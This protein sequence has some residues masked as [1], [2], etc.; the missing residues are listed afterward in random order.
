MNSSIIP[1]MSDNRG[2]TVTGSKARE[3]PDEEKADL[4]SRL[5]DMKISQTQKPVQHPDKPKK[6]LQS[7]PWAGPHKQSVFVFLLRGPYLYAVRNRAG[8]LGAPGGKREPGDKGLGGT[9]CREFFEETGTKLPTDKPFSHFEWG[10]PY[11]TIRVYYRHLSLVESEGFPSMPITN[12]PDQEEVETLWAY[13]PD[14]EYYPADR[15]FR[16]HISRG[17]KIYEAITESG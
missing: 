3:I 4:E 9:A 6:Q 16:P 14:R 8:I 11:H 5:G 10:T 13:Y 7:R 1:P 15:N 17:L 2:T 12:D